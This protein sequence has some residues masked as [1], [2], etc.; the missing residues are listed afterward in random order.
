M[1]ARASSVSDHD[2]AVAF[3][4]LLLVA[5]VGELVLFAVYTAAGGPRSTAAIVLILA[6]ILLMLAGILGLER[7]ERKGVGFSI[8]DAWRRR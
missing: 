4:R 8:E 3:L 6:G 2:R 7:L 1:R 5:F